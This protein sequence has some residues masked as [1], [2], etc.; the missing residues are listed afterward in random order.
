MNN[1]KKSSGCYPILI[2]LIIFWLIVIWFFFG[3]AH[4]VPH[5]LHQEPGNRKEMYVTPY[6]VYHKS[7]LD[8][9]SKYEKQ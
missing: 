5:N 1:N 7:I 3:C 2:A 8:D 4:I 9:L 6:G